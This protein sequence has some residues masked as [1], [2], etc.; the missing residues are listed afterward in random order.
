VLL[1]D[2]D[3]LAIEAGKLV[4]LG[5]R[6]GEI[7]GA[8]RVG[9]LARLADGRVLVLG[10]RKAW[11][12][13]PASGKLQPLRAPL[14]GGGRLALRLSDDRVLVVSDD[15]RGT[16]QIYDAARDEWSATAPF[17]KFP[18]AATLLADGRPLVVSV[19]RPAG[20]VRTPDGVT[21]ARVLDLATLQWTDVTV[22]LASS[23]ALLADG[24]LAAGGSFAPPGVLALDGTWTRGEGP[25]AAVIVGPDEVPRFVGVHNPLMPAGS[26]SAAVWTWSTDGFHE[27]APLAAVPGPSI[28]SGFADERGT[29]TLFVETAGRLT[30]WQP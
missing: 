16:A 22:P 25:T 3:A 4:R 24:R 5:S 10:G 26:E 1:D 28:H 8:D 17:G 19:S 18:R 29:L 13:D 14:Q 9:A 21:W 23:L 15:G 6:P 7:A 30:R 27:G 11:A 12:Y 2:C 20:D